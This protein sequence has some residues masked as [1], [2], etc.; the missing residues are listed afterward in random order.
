MGGMVGNVDQ[1]G[2]FIIGVVAAGLI[3]ALLSLYESSQQ[4]H[5]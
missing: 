1:A 4:S 3:Y 5:Q 2:A